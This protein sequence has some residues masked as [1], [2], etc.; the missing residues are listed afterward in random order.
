ME[1]YS[2]LGQGEGPVVGEGKRDC[3]GNGS[4]GPGSIGRLQELEQS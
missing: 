4:I 2:G 3:I 1:L